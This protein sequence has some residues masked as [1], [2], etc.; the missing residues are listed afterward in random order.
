MVSIQHISNSLGTVHDIQAVIDVAHQ[1]AVPVMIDAAQSAA[2]FDLD[3][4]TL[5]YDFLAFSG[6]KVFGPFGIGVLFVSPEFQKH[7]QPYK[8]GGGIIK[9]VQLEETSFSDFPNVLD[10]G[11][12]NVSG[13]IGLGAAIDFLISCDRES[14]KKQQQDLIQTAEGLLSNIPAVN[15]LGAPKVRSSIISFSI[16]GIHA[17]EVASF[18][19]QDNVAVRAGMHCT[20]PLLDHMKTPATVRMSLSI[21][22]TIDDLQKMIKSINELI[23]FWS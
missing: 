13:V 12:P 22:N 6:H 15:I 19:N 10:V 23:K 5:Q 1:H 8:F 21:Y 9:D 16:E 20:Q 14:L 3:W 7:V 11:T 17:H 4:K 18:L 2:L